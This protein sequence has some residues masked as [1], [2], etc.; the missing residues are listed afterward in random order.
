MVGK[1]IDQIG[2]ARRSGQQQYQQ[3]G[4]KTSSRVKP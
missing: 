2:R 1:P 3:Q 4:G